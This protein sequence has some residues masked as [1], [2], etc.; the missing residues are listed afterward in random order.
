MITR[1]LKAIVIVALAVRIAALAWQ[2]IHPL[3]FNPTLQNFQ[4]FTGF[5]LPQLKWLGQGYL[6][7]RD[8]AYSNTP[9][10]VYLLYPFYVLAPK[11]A[12]L[13][14]V[15]ADAL[16]APVIYLIVRRSASERIA[17]IA[18]F[19]YALSPFA[20]VYEGISWLSEQPMLLLLLIS[21]YFLGR[22]RP[23]SSAI[24][25]GLAIMIKQDAA[26]VLPAYLFWWMR[27]RGLKAG[28]IPILLLLMITIAVSAP[29]LVL[30]QHEYP[31]IITFGTLDGLLPHYIPAP[32]QIQQLGG[33]GGLE[34]L[35]LTSVNTVAPILT[36]TILTNNIFGLSQVCIGAISGQTLT[37]FAFTPPSTAVQYALDAVVLILL[38]PLLFELAL[39][40]KKSRFV[41]SIAVS[42]ALLI[43]PILAFAVLPDN[44]YYLLP[45]YTLLLASSTDRASLGIATVFPI[46]AL[47]NP[48]G[49]LTELLPVL[50]MQLLAVNWILQR[51]RLRVKLDPSLGLHGDFELDEKSDTRAHLEED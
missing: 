39:V 18:S 1:A 40:P 33:L 10:F 44:K 37:N 43:V 24:L 32:L 48:Y 46:I 2:V 42:N 5:Y 17:L 23:N 50:E 49:Y 16:T 9:L 4:D 38:V 34:T 29:F 36:C 20:I 12:A 19:A 28:I 27:R 51:N 11:A 13:P 3:V 41:F 22:D 21:V 6:P 31:Q 47:A 8:F 35:P 15:I 14:I 25:L 26:F 7:Y 45:L 30:A